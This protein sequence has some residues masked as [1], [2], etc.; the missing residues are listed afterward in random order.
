MEPAIAGHL[1]AAR[2]E[3][4]VHAWGER[5]VETEWQGLCL[6]LR[7]SRKSY[8]WK[9]PRAWTL[10]AAA[11]VACGAVASTFVLL[12]A[13]RA[14]SPG[15]NAVATS[16]ARPER[17][18]LGSGAEVQVG[19]ATRLDV[20]ERTATR[21]VVALHAGSAR[22]DVRHDPR[23]L[24]RVHAGAV[25]VE[26]LGTKFEVEHRGLTARVSVTEGSVS[27]SFPEPTGEARSKVTLDAG[28]SAIFPA[29]AAFAQTP[30]D[31]HLTDAPPRA[32]PKT[33]D[34]RRNAVAP[35][36]EG[37]RELAR[38][39]KHGGAY[40]LL[41][42]R[43]FRDVGDDPSD[44]LL[45]S[46]AARLSRHPAQAVELLRRLL[47]RHERDPR[48]PSAAFTLGWLLLNELNRPRE[49]ASAFAR[50]EALAPRGNLAEDAIARAVEAWY[51]AGDLTRASA[52]VARYRKGH[53]N[54]RHLAML[55]RLVGTR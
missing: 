5:R 36:P 1:D 48:A 52:E 21:V 44:L 37:W 2:R 12:R 46:D 32:L 23:R 18:E 8:E 3:L 50:A 38:T 42:P 45:A 49:A 17:V 15:V 55:E 13:Q 53:P 28:K 29:V 7:G 40:E 16:V 54:G 39:G 33:D 47:A 19:P 4:R 20:V 10:A 11:L 6:R 22:F 35:S 24:I 34:V 14:E 41:A 27:V 43:N 25:A 51:R 31:E 26:D 30:A 9:A